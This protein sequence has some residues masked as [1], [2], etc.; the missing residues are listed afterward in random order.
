MAYLLTA[1]VTNTVPNNVWT[2]APRSAAPRL[3]AAHYRLGRHLAAP[4]LPQGAPTSPAL[5]NLAAFGLDRRLSALADSRGLAYSRYAD[6]LALS[7]SAHLRPSQVDSLATVVA[8]IASEEGFRVNPAR[9][10]CSVGASASGSRAGHKRASQYRPSR[11]R[12]VEGHPAQRRGSWAPTARTATA[13]GITGRPYWAGYP[14][15]ARSTRTGG[16]I[17]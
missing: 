11:V 1:F 17:Y 2:R 5:A 16:N 4:H 13:I 14:A 10:P 12:P 8:E 15:C 9:L 7:S 6:D 3:R